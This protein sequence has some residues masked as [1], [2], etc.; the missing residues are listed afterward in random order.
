[1]FESKNLLGNAL[2]SAIYDRLCSAVYYALNYTIEYL[3]GLEEE[4]PSRDKLIEEWRELGAY[5]VAGVVVLSTLPEAPS[6]CHAVGLI[7]WIAEYLRDY[8]EEAVLPIVQQWLDG[9]P[10]A[11]RISANPQ[12]E[13]MKV[14][15]LKRLVSAIDENAKP[16]VSKIIRSV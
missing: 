1:V 10:V 4:P 7:P 6:L 8:D 15:E 3:D 11:E 5:T 13:E 14:R 16:T 12:D 9:K 2:Q